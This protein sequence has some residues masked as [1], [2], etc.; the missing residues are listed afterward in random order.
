M[1]IKKTVDFTIMGD[2]T[3]D[4]WQLTEWVELTQRDNHNKA[5]GLKTKVKVLYSD[6]GLYILFHN[7]DKVLNSTFDSHFEELWREDVVEVFL[8]TDESRPVYFEYELSPLNFELPLIVSNIDGELIHWIPFNN[9]YKDERKTRHK[10]AI[11]GGEKESGAHI[12][13]W[14]AE[15][16]IPYKL[17]H[18]LENIIPDSGTRW[19]ANLYRIDYDEGLTPWSWQ[20]YE[21]NFHDYNNF[22]TFLFE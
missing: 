9:S 15:I 21:T 1:L 5:S 12:D 7:E 20:S 14:M 2:G 18:P 10:T 19:R 3:A 13:L 4:N 17:L 6:T 16:F 11:F 8:W 22:G